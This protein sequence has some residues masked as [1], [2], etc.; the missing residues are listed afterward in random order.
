[1]FIH[2]VPSN[3]RFWVVRSD[4]GAYYSHF[5]ANSLVAIGHLDNMDYSQSTLTNAEEKERLLIGYR[6]SLIDNNEQLASASNKAGQVSR[7]IN[8]MNI[9]DYVITLS[10]SR[11]VVGVITSQAYK[12]TESVTILNDDGSTN[13]SLMQYSLRRNVMWGRSQDRGELPLVINNSFRANQTVFS[14]N[15]HWKELNHWMSVAFI[16]DGEAYISAR[17]E[18]REGINN[19]DIA[20]Y[21]IIIN[22]IEAIAESLVQNSTEHMTNEELILLF[23]QTYRQLRT[24][25]SFTVTTQ[26]VFLSPGDLWAK[27]SGGRQKSLVFV[28][29]FLMMFGTPV[30]FSNQNDESFINEHRTAIITML[31]EVKVDE[32]F[33][34]VRD[35]LRLR[36]PRQKIT[37]E[38]SQPINNQSD[39]YELDNFEGM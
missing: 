11:I 9:G 1:M 32:D 26:Q 25:R 29:A 24:D 17:I 28:C 13:E 33:D 4:G 7:F 34:E 23:K 21:A 27:I 14:A 15:E 5:L 36:I 2:D 39:D 3:R 22:K 6:R 30:T 18:Q 8:E 20:Q 19:L 37:E 16:S 10:A 12:S 31:N 38:S 35:G